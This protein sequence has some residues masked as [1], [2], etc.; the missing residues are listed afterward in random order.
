MYITTAIGEMP[1]I[2]DFS[3]QETSNKRLK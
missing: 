2:K 3:K 1:L